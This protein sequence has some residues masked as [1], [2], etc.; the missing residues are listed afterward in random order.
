MTIVRTLR[1]QPLA[2]IG[3]LL[4]VLFVVMALLAPWLAPFDPA[5]INLNQRLASPSSIS[6]VWHRRA[7][8]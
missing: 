5:A 2:I 1:H 7:G 8:A 4:L 6:L 3:L